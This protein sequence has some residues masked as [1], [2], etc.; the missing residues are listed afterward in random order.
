LTHAYENTQLR[1]LAGG[2]ENDMQFAA[3]TRS[4]DNTNDFAG[5][6]RENGQGSEATAPG[7]NEISDGELTIHGI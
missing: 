3:G 1:Q 7:L 4:K 5:W 2:S 6:F